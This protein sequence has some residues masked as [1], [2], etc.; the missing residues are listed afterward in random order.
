MPVNEQ[1]LQN[2]KIILAKFFIELTAGIINPSLLYQ[3][4]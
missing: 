1:E 3:L 2:L 4:C